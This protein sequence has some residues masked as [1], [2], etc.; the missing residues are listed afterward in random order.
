MTFDRLLSLCFLAASVAVIVLAFSLD[1]DPRGLGTHEQLGLPPCGFLRDHGVPCISCGMTTAFA[2]LAHGDP[3]LALRSNPFGALLFLVAVLAPFHFA[4]A[5]VTGL[6][7]LRLMRHP[8]A[9]V[10]LPIAGSLL[11]ANWG[12]MVLLARAGGAG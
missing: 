12:V 4:H 10:I 8:R 3:A 6:D 7:P 9:A 1:P 11:L 5:L 2:A